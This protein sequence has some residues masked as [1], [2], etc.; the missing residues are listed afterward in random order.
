MSA[1]MQTLEAVREV[2]VETLGIEDSRRLLHAHTALFGSLPELDS[3]GVLTLAMA[4][5]SR[6]AFQIEDSEFSADVFETLGTLADFVDQKR[7]HRKIE[8]VS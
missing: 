2:V 8:A 6:F 4:L 3:F 1:D 7:S 5:E